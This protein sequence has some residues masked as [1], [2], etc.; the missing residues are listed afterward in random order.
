MKDDLNE[1]LNEIEQII[2]RIAAFDLEEIKFSYKE[3]NDLTRLF[4]NKI[5]Q[6]KVLKSRGLVSLAS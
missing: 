4:H 3:R 2:A 5:N 1:L 6:A